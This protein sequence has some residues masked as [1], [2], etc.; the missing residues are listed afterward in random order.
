MRDGQV[1]QGACTRCG[2]WREFVPGRGMRCRDCER[3]DSRARYERSRDV[4]LARSRRYVEEHA[5]HVATQR[6]AGRRRRRVRAIGDRGGICACCG[7]GELVFLVIVEN[8]VYCRNCRGINRDGCPHVAS[9]VWGEGKGAF[10][11]R[12]RAEAIEAYGGVCACCTEAQIEFLQIDHLGEDGRAHRR[13]LG[14]TEIY[15][16]LRARGWPTGFQVLCA[17]CNWA[18]T[19]GG[20]PHQGGDSR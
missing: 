3:A 6:A 2:E 1:R 19:L 4:F 14:Y 20:C 9:V 17:N 11:R 15:S 13:E 10:W 12:L 18:K 5:E 8:E 7:E 16:W